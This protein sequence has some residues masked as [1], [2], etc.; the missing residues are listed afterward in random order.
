MMLISERDYKWASEL[1]M[2]EVY[3]PVSGGNLAS[4]DLPI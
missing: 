1:R 3:I 2:S 4:H